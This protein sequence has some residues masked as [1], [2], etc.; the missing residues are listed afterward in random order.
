MPPPEIPDQPGR[1]VDHQAGAADDQGI[2]LADRRHGPGDNALVQALLIQHHIRLDDA[3]ALGAAGHPGAVG[4]KLHIVKS[5][6]VHAVIAQGAPVQLIHRFGAGCLMQAVDVLGDDRLQPALPLQLG[7]P[8]VGRIGLCPFYN[9]LIAVKAVE[10]LRVLLPERMAQDGFR[11][12]VV[13]LVIQPV[14]APEIRDAAF[15]GNA[16]TAKKDD[17]AAFRNDFFQCRN[18]K[19]K[20]PF[21]AGRFVCTPVPS[22]TQICRKG[23]VCFGRCFSGHSPQTGCPAR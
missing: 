8:Q 9:E 6:A 14:H 15:G 17:A 23:S 16:R 21:P 3:A 1:R 10:L 19:K 2:G 22:I 18:H 12:V 11:R 13:G 7:Q 20:R 5:T 4:H